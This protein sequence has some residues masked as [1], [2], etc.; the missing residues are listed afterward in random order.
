LQKLTLADA[1]LTK[2][3]HGGLIFPFEKLA[4]VRYAKARL[5]G[6]L[7]LYRM[8]RYREPAAASLSAH[9]VSLA[10]KFAI[11]VLPWV[12]SGLKVLEENGQLQM[13]GEFL[14]PVGEGVVSLGR[15][16][17]GLNWQ[18]D[19]LDRLLSL[20]WLEDEV[21]FDLE[22]VIVASDRVA[23]EVRRMPSAVF[24]REFLSWIPNAL[25]Y[26]INERES[27]LWC[28]RCGDRT[29]VRP[30]TGRDILKCRYCSQAYQLEVST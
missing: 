8:T 29:T 12:A 20:R 14:R 22:E 9:E 2:I 28:P 18:N 25:V 26:P 15:M 19:E 30:R 4:G 16:K 6:P 27:V 11:K 5:H 21:P 23:D 10:K 3:E 1:G 13:L 7:V 17:W 24:H